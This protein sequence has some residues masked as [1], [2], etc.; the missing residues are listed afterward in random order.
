MAWDPTDSVK[1]KLDTMDQ[2]HWRKYQF[3]WE[4]DEFKNSQDKILD[5]KE[6]DFLDSFE[7]WAKVLAIMIEKHV[8]PSFVGHEDK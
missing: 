2:G 1:P 4:A 7:E 6:W 5:Q 8:I 3:T